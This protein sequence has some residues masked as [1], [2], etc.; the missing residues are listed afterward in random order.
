MVQDL[1]ADRAPLLRYAGHK[2]TQGWQLLNIS[3]LL[4]GLPFTVYSGVQQTGVGSLGADRP[5]ELIAPNLSTSRTAREDYFERGAAESSFF[6]IP[7]HVIGGT[8][9]NDGV[10][11]NLGR[12][13]FR[14][15]EWPTST[16]R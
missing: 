8:G 12:D 14:D 16:S 1:H 5:D 11:G 4:S 10:F 13:T 6:S 9:P 2:L 3:T 15:L 7:T